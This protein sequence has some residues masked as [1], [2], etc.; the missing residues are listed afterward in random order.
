MPGCM[1]V[2]GGAVY[3]GGPQRLR[4]WGRPAAGSVRKALHMVDGWA[5]G[6]RFTLFTEDFFFCANTLP[7]SWEGAPNWFIC[8]LPRL[9]FSFG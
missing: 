2:L 9:P 4:Q 5:H 3:F 8:L 7:P 1:R 6:I